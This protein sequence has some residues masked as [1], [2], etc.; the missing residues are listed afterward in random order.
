MSPLN[1][2][3]RERV[4]D[5][6]PAGFHPPSAMELGVTHPDSGFG[7][8]YGWHAPADEVI[9][10]S[11]RQLYTRKNPTIFPGPLYLWAWNPDWIAKGQ[12]LLRLA[13]EIPNVMIIPMPDYRPKYPKIDPEEGINPNHP[14]L[15][16]WHN[17][18]EVALFIGIHCHYANLALRMVRAGTNC[19][20]IA[21]CHDIHE[22]AMLSVQDLDVTYMDHVIE[23][24]RAVRKDLGVEMPT[25]GKT[26]RLTGTQIRANHGVEC[27]NPFPSA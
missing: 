12:A 23:I 25:D 17:K 10:E 7:L 6:G 19:L 3:Q 2:A 22:D 8:S 27:V 16:I 26:V 24:F 18:I 4:I 5:V 13:A 9:A 14:N 20:T 1:A 21:F 11:A 15:T